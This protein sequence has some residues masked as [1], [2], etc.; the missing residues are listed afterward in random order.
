MFKSLQ[1]GG[2]IKVIIKGW[3]KDN[4]VHLFSSVLDRTYGGFTP[5][6]GLGKEC[7][8]S[9]TKLRVKQG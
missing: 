2:L 5:A 9:S 1:G 7:F 3:V 8:R 4:I 6:A